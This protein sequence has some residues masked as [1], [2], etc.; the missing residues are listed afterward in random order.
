[1]IDNQCALV[2][3]DADVELEEEGL[4]G[5]GGDLLAGE[6]NE[7]I[8]V[9]LKEFKKVV[10][11]QSWAEAF[12]LC[13][14]QEDVVVGSF[15]MLEEGDFVSLGRFDS[16]META[17]YIRMSAVSWSSTVPLDSNWKLWSSCSKDN[18]QAYAA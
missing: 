3:G 11:G 2:A 9:F 10:G 15:I 5:G 13:G 7:N 17:S 1:M 8:S 6:R 12:R 4:D 16:C 18:L 14:E